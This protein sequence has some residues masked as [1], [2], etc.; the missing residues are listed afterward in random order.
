MQLSFNA[1]LFSEQLFF[2]FYQAFLSFAKV[3]W[4]IYFLLPSQPE[5]RS[6]SRLSIQKGSRLIVGIIEN[7][8]C[9][10]NFSMAMVTE[11]IL[12]FFENWFDI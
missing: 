9:H 6:A 1:N 11:M 5:P 3:S 10:K 7:F 4:G 2:F 8:Y 12:L